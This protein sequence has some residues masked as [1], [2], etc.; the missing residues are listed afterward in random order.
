MAIQ[1]QREMWGK[2][3]TIETGALARQADGAVLVRMEDTVVLV[4]A[5]SG[6]PREGIDFSFSYP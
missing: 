3:L 2:T 4:S 6:T 1:V 5:V